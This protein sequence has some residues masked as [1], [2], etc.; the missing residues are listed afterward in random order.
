MLRMRSLLPRRETTIALVK[1]E[2]MG[3][4]AFLYRRRARGSTT[5]PVTA[6]DSQACG[7]VRRKVG[8]SRQIIGKCKGNR[9]PSTPELD[10]SLDLADSV[11]VPLETTCQDDRLF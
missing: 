11:A 3:L 4:R 6:E 10:K 8:C 2:C 7:H 5:R 9:D 1:S